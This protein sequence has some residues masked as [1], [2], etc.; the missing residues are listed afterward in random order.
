VLDAVAGIVAEK[1]AKN[2]AREGEP[3][4]ERWL[5]IHTAEPFVEWVDFSAELPSRIFSPIQFD[6]V[7]LV[8]DY[9]PLTRSYPWWKINARSEKSAEI[10]ER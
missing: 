6:R 10:P 5:V 8:R 2:F 3:Y 9:D 7:Y 1:D 4:A